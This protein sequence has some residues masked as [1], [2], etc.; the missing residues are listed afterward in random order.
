MLLIGTTT[1]GVTPTMVEAVADSN[2]GLKMHTPLWCNWTHNATAISLQN[3]LTKS[4]E[5]LSIL[6]IMNM[7]KC[8][9]FSL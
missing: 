3:H 6:A 4:N 9:T 2:H 8:V 5:P 1:K 7:L